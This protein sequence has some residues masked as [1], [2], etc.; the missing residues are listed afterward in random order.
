MKIY[1]NKPAMEQI[2]GYARSGRMPHSILLFGDEGTGKRTLAD[3]IA[4]CWFCESGESFPCMSCRECKR[5]EEH[6][7]PDVI[8][9]DCSSID[10]DGMRN[11]LKSSFEMPVEGKI[12]VYIWQEFQLLSGENQNSLLTRL[13]EPSEKVRFILTA[14][15]KNGVL[16]TILSR[17]AV[18]RTYPLTVSECASALNERGFSDCEKIAELYGGNLGLALKAAEDKNSSVYIDAARAFAE[19]VCDNNEYRALII[20]LSLPQPKEDKRRPLRETVFAAE[21][22][23][24]DGFA[25]ASGGSGGLGCDREL[26][27]RLSER[28]SAAVLNRLC[29]ICGRFSAV[30][31]DVNFNGKITV[32][33]FT[34]AIFR[35]T[36]KG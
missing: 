13:E 31:N 1:G 14:S 11:V 35:E 19:A 30:A 33:A 20:L 2:N 9:T 23:I 6:I 32:N 12:R 34:A 27:K 22:L 4:L 24:H 5:V 17:A 21:R 8:R 10:K 3:Y 25:I 36:A 28:Y 16:P 29:E 7:H 15:N 18:I 26:S